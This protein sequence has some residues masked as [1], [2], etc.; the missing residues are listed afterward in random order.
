[1]KL[2]LIKNYFNPDIV[3]DIG[4][5]IGQFRTSFLKYYPNSWIF[6]I[7]ASKDC[8]P[9]LKALTE[10]YYIGLL[11]KDDNDYDF[12][13]IP[14]DPLCTGMSTY[15]EVTPYWKQAAAIKKKGIKLDN[16]FENDWF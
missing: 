1:M 11:N 15:K 5:N 14:D 16:L 13:Y 2:E 8:E 4:A 3:L 9:Y 10:D 12:Y 6:S 7:E